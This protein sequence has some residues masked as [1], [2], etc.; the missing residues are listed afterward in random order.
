M[1]KSHLSRQRLR[2]WV[3]IEY[4]TLGFSWFPPCTQE[5]L[6]TCLLG[7]TDEQAQGEGLAW[8]L[9]PGSR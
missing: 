3:R 9:N 7:S 1:C 4:M 5:V 8:D 2:P 6:A